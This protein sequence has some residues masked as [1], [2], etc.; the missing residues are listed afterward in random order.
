MYNQTLNRDRKYFCR[1]C[2]QSLS[3]AKISERHIND[4]F[5]INRLQIIK[6]AKKVKLLN[7]KTI[8]E[9]KN[10]YS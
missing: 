10:Y 6:M 5:E 7:L 9:K 8:R 1:Y 2:L 3:T 4:C